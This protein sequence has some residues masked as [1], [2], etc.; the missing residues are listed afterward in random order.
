MNVGE[1][2][3]VHFWNGLAVDK[4]WLHIDLTWQQFPA[5]STVK[6]FEALDRTDLQ[7][8]DATQWRCAEL[9][10]RVQTYLLAMT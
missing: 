9:L 7:D 10:K 4:D 3:E 6:Q 1:S 5:G 2:E 8:S